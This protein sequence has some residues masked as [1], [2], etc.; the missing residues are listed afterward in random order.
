MPVILEVIGPE[1][2]PEVPSV[3]LEDASGLKG[4][5]AERVIV[6]ADEAGVAAALREASAAGIPVTVSGAGTGVA[7]GRVPFGGW[8]LSLEKFTRLEIH[9]GYAVAG[10]G[11]LLRDVHAAAQ[12]LGTILSARPHRDRR[13]HRRQ[14]RLQRQRVAEFPLWR[15]RRLGRAPARGARRRAH[16]GCRTRR[17][18][19]FRPRH[20]PAAGR[21]QEHR[22]LPAASGHGLGGSVR[23]FRRHAGCRHRGHAAPEAGAQGSARRPGLL[24]QRR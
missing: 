13:F 18:H 16:S 19:R 15:H 20:G 24:S 14:H 5:H 12:S 11:V 8:V 6:P 22:R 23:R 4:G 9:P 3:Y 1:D 7:G 17:A 2:P 21:H 10:A